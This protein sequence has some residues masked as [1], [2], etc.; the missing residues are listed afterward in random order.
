MTSQGYREKRVISLL[1]E[2]TFK[3]KYC[4][5][6]NCGAHFTPM[7]EALGISGTAFKPGVRRAAA[8]LAAADAF[9]GAS[10]T[11]REIGGVDVCAKDVER[12]AESIGASIQ[13]E[14]D[15]MIDDAFS[16]CDKL[17]DTSPGVPVL[18]IEYDGTGIPVTKKE[19]QGRLGKQEGGQAK[20]REMKTGCIFTQHGIDDRGRPVRDKKS[21]TYFAAIESAEDF[22]RRVYAEA[23][24]RGAQNAG[25]VVILGDGAKWIWNI[26]DT[27]FPHA[28]QIVDLYHAKEHVS[29]LLKALVPNE[30]ERK[31]L[32]DKMVECLDAGNIPAL[33]ALMS[34]LP[35]KTED[36]R[37]SIERE[38]GYFLNNANR[39]NY[40]MYKAQGYFVGSGVIEATCK[41]VIGK[42]L[43]QSGMHWSTR[44][45]N[46]IATLRC[47]VLSGEFDQLSAA[48]VAA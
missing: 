6:E 1:G 33:I 26:A 11:L 34:E 25:T 22:G 16:E 41:N 9:E 43:K 27:H 2:G 15:A 24:R 10:V 39:I 47:S 12:I 14:C 23:T 37:A 29:D 32:N 8:R 18:Y 4:E 30:L 35:A 19:T 20:T 45:A 5:C 17:L 13:K 38:T 44:G 46:S 42:R 3:R 48:T 7:D 21:T 40:A 28:V 36:D 31:P